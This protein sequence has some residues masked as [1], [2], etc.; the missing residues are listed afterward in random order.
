MWNDPIFEETRRLRDEY[1]AKHKY[2]IHEMV[3]DLNQWEKQ[4]FP[5][6]ASLDSNVIELL[7]RRSAENDLEASSLRSRIISSS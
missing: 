4:G 5:M 1:S 7:A 3:E 2:S 6:P